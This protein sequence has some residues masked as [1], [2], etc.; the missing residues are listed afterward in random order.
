[1]KSL[2][3]SKFLVLFIF[4][5]ATWFT[6]TVQAG[7]SN[8]AFQGNDEEKIKNIIDSY[9]QIRYESFSTLKLGD[10]EGLVSEQPDARIWLD[11]ELSKL[12]VELRHVELNNLR[13]M[14][15]K[16]FLNFKE[17]SIDNGETAFVNVLISHDV[18]REVSLDLNPDNPNISHL[19]NLEHK[20]TLHQENG[21]WKITS[22][23][24]TD[25]LWR[26]LR[27]NDT[28][29][30]EVLQTMKESPLPSLR[31]ASLQTEFSCGL[32]ADDSTHSYN[33][34]G[35][36][37]Y[38]L[39]HVVNYNPNYPSYDSDPRFGDCTNFVSQALYEGGNVSMAFCST[40]GPYCSTGSDGNLGWFFE[41]ESFRASAW[42][43]VG[44][45]HEFVL[46]PIATQS[47]GWTEGP[48][49]CEVDNIAYLDIGDVIQYEWGD[50]D[51]EWDHAVIIV[52]F[53]NGVPLIASHSENVGPELYTYFSYQ[54]I[55]FIHIERSDGYSNAPT[56]TPTPTLP[57]SQTTNSSITQGSNDGGINPTPCEFTLEDN[58]VYLEACFDGGDITSGFRFENI[59]VPRN[60]NIENAYVR[61][62]VDGEYTTPIQV[63]INGEASGNPLI[64]SE[65]SPPTN[66]VK[67]YNSA[68]WNITET[69]NLGEQ[70]NTPD[71]S[72]IIREIVI[73]DD[74]NP[75]QPIS[76]IIS[77]AGSTDVRRVIGFERAEGDPDLETAELI[78][79]YNTNPTPTPTSQPPNSTPLPT[80]TPIIIQPTFTPLPVTPKPTNPPPAKVPWIC[81]VCGIGCPASAQRLSSDS[82]NT[83]G[84]PTAMPYSSTPTPQISSLRIAESIE[85]TDL[86]YRVRDELLNTTPEGQ[87]LSDLYYTYIPNIV[88]VL[89]VH[90]ELSDSS[91]ETMNLF[92][93]SLQALLDGNGDS[94]VI[95]TEQVQGLQSFLDA[96]VQYGDEDLQSV[97][98]AELEKHPLENLIG[99]TM[100]G[101]WSQINGYEFEW[102][103]PLGNA[104]P[105]TTKQGSTI[106][107]K[108]SL[109]DFEGNF[110]TDETVYLQVTDS[111]GNIVIGP[112][113]INNN[114]NTG[115]KIQ[116]NQYHYNLKTKDLP[117]GSYTLEV[118][119]NNGIQSEIKTIVLTKK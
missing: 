74:W 36:V 13:Y 86:L 35:A 116:G 102:L 1:M 28:P 93:P 50:N 3:S 117:V 80:S 114:P 113:Q 20:I 63:Q 100:N 75:G 45:F 118:L 78:I 4:F 98:L 76:L 39:T 61:F 85:L 46:D 25:Y 32:P 26:M 48:E 106:P 51:G 81:S 52:G 34:E 53:E 17:I 21:R 82:V 6:S 41:S 47:A 33:R 89:M 56:S 22:D 12:K 38:A 40:S 31:I 77:N 29:I 30:D 49:G 2:N 58:E 7:S 73:R 8:I 9:F 14:D 87:R 11:Q 111:N 72:A 18:V 99:L 88:Q 60:A 68:L 71:L 24:Y 27:K 37:N 59:Q 112:V 43:H 96:L 62:T 16:F 5:I 97:I 23:D 103:Q 115:I 55:R 108:F 105:Y 42:T 104:N 54:D 90:P 44:K 91:F 66:R 109:T 69:W 83:Y 94:V 65:A 110:A 92:A 57:P 70:Y 107:V 19:Y 67:T 64:Y 101:A 10:F 79:T 84:T 119:Y 15:Y 95:T